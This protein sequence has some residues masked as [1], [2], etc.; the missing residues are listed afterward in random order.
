MQVEA[1]VRRMPVRWTDETFDFRQSV[2]L[3]KSYIIASLPRS[4][5]QLLASELWKTGRAGAPCE[6]LFPTYDM[7]P[8]MNRLKSGSPADYIAKLLACRTSPNGVFGL[9]VHLQHFKAFLRAYPELTQALSPLTFIH[10]TRRNK[11]AQAVSMAKAYQTSAWTSQ[12]KANPTVKYDRKLIEMCLQDLA[13][14]EREWEDWF[15]ANDVKPLRVI[16]E[17]LAADRPGT[18]R[19]I[20]EQLGVQDDEPVAVELPPVEKQSDSTNKE[21][22]ARFEAEIADAGNVV[23]GPGA[24]PDASGA[25]PAAGLY[26]RFINNLPARMSPSAAYVDALR[27]RQLF[28][29]VVEQNRSLFENAR[30]L[31]FPAIDGR[32]GL[33]AL[34]VDAAYVIGIEPMRRFAAKADSTFAEYGI[35]RNR[36]EFINAN[37]FAAA[38]SFEPDSFDLILCAKFER[39]D[40]QQ[41][42]RELQR[43]QPRFVILDTAVTPDRGPVLRFARQMQGMPGPNA[44]RGNGGGITATPSH[45]LIAFLCDFFGFRWHSPDWES[46]EIADWTGLHDFRRGGRRIYVLERTW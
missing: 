29:V 45:D 43:L 25:P 13:Q 40:P 32:W 10:T 38:A 19:S 23:P 26:E 6:Y 4:G 3:R 24:L 31:V 44:M 41:T 28:K 1:S 14:Q 36:Y 39:F 21:W 27:S 35:E 7:R 2:P 12:M 42:F 37:F 20:L 18:V 8:M 30:V 16:Y 11:V 5:S 34:D 9:N 17:D 22:I 33:A 46:L 15:A